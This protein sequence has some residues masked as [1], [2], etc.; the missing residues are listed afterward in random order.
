MDRKAKLW[1]LVIVVALLCSACSTDNNSG[2]GQGDETKPP[3]KV[4]VEALPTGTALPP[5]PTEAATVAPTLEPTAAQV[6]I[7]PTVDEDALA[8]QI[9]AMMDDI[10]QKLKSQNINIKP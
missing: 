4:R 8:N 10:D 5:L 7:E 6:Y 9:E 3:P 2:K 1:I